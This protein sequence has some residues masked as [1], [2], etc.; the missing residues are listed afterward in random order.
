M[1]L[2]RANVLFDLKPLALGSGGGD[3]QWGQRKRVGPGLLVLMQAKGLFTL[4]QIMTVIMSASQKSYVTF[5]SA[6]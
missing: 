6:I 1:H 4:R 2:V 5:L 3:T